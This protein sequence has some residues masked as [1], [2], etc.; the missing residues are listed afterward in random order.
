MTKLYA[1]HV[2]GELVCEV[3]V[4]D[5]GIPVRPKIDRMWLRSLLAR[6]FRER[7]YQCDDAR[8]ACPVAD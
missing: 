5:P 7:T 1:L 3:S 8:T 6:I 4:E 2:N